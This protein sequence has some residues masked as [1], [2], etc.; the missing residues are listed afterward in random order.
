MPQIKRILCYGDSLTAG[1]CFRGSK[2]YPYASFLKTKLQSSLIGVT[3]EVDH[4]GF[5]GK[6]TKDLID[7]AN[8]DC[9]KDVN[10]KSGPGIVAALRKKEYDVVVLMTGTNDLLHGESASTIFAN[11][12]KLTNL[13]FSLDTQIKHLINIGIPDSSAF[14]SGNDRDQLH[15]VNQWLADHN[16]TGRSYIDCPLKYSSESTSFDADGLHFSES[17][18][19]NF[20]AGILDSVEAAL[21]SI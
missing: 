6:T 16:Q 5:C 11:I 13:A 20:A 19:N 12:Q 7:N 10:G 9:F 4:F 15:L 14:D 8:A 3:I 17:G 18:S 21:K 2:Y 1:F